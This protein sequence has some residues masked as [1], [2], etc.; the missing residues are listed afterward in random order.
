MALVRS[1]QP[2]V[3]DE[4]IAAFRNGLTQADL[5]NL[6][7]STQAFGIA[8]Q[9]APVWADAV[10]NRGV[11]LDRQGEIEGA[12]ADLQQ[13]LSLDPAGEDGIAV[14]QRIGQ[15][16][17]AVPLPS[18]GS[19]LALGILFPGMGQFYSGRALG[20][21]TVLALAGGAVAAGF[22]I[23][24]VVTNCVGTA[25]QGGVCPPDRFISEETTKPY[26]T[27]SLIA[28]GAVTLIGA[29]E[30]FLKVRRGESDENGDLVAFNV[31]KARI[32]GPSVSAEGPRLN[33]SLFRVTF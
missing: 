29:I 27:Q 13:Y 31:G 24:E 11:I 22:L 7:E 17:S 4:A 30:A 2:R 9:L 21:F 14:S 6:E 23:E 12:L 26:Q 20:G 15:L 32:V 19:T 5:G 28:A 18:P 25:P 1:E 33:L 8:F 10:Y 3:S 16:Q